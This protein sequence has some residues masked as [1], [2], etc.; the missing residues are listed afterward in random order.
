MLVVDTEYGLEIG[1]QVTL[2][3]PLADHRTNDRRPAQTTAD[4]NLETQ[5]A[6][7]IGQQFHADIVRVNCGS[8]LL[9]GADCDL[10]LARQKG[11]LR[12][13]GRPLANDF[14]PG[15][16]IFAFVGG[17]SRELVG[18]GIANTIAAGLYGVHLHAG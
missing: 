9:T 7:S 3:Q 17:Y 10:E 18:R 5:L 8:I 6:R 14:T 12:M 1:Q 15:A 11:E 4:Q 13:Q 16:R 2:L